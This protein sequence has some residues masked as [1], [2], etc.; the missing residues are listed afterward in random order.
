VSR[1]TLK[2]PGGRSNRRS[3]PGGGESR[4]EGPRFLKLLLDAVEQAVIATDAAGRILHWNRFAERMYGW[5]SAEVVGKGVADILLPEA[6]RDRG[7]AAIA[8]LCRGERAQGEWE[9]RRRDGTMIPVRATSTPILDSGGSIVGIVGVSLDISE[10]KRLEQELHQSENRLRA[11]VEQL[12]ALAWTTDAD[13]RIIWNLGRAFRPMSTDPKVLVGETIAEVV[14]RHDGRPAAIEAHQRALRGE[15][16][17]YEGGGRGRVLQAVVQPFRDSRG[18]ITGTVG[19]ALDITDH[20]RVESELYQKREQLHA[21]SGRLLV[22]QEAERHALAREL[23]DELGQVLT[24]IRLNLESARSADASVRAQHITECIALV[25]Q[26]MNQTRR[27]ALDLRPAILDDLGL[28]AALRSLLKRQSEH[29]GF[30]GRFSVAE[31]NGRLSAALETCSFRLVQEAL[32]NV[33]RHAGAKTVDVELGAADGEL[34][35]QVRDDGKGFDVARAR[36]AAARGASLGLL[37]MQE[38]VALCGGRIEI[39]SAPGKGTSL[40]AH[41]PLAWDGA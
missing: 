26:A 15:T 25:D 31:L 40:D 18:N 19:V 23:H 37:S 41:L 7:R 14:G 24:A 6:Q 20:R 36:L 34:R 12:P 35:I 1:T 22:A 38:R 5:R 30:E 28:V 11:I 17:A 13:L 16:V 10:K 39:Q 32:T 33:A 9:L 8:A 3:H 4:E 21:L 27:L 2:K 29:G